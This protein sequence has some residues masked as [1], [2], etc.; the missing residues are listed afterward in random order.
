M[1]RDT[2][3]SAIVI[4]ASSGGL[5]ALS[6]LLSAIPKNYMLPIIVVQHRSKEERDLLETVLQHKCEIRIK[7]ADEKEKITGGFVYIAPPNY[8]LMVESDMTFSLSADA[9]VKFSRPSIDV[10]FETASHV[11]TKTLIGI[12]LTGSGSDGASGMLSIKENN[13]VTI[14]QD[15]QE[16][17][18]PAMPIAAIRTGA[19][20]RVL[21]LKEIV[22]FLKQVEKTPHEKL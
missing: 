11:Y 7:Q 21:P 15:P 16:A 20:N 17:H 12:I 22:A 5:H 13:G 10:L 2:Y 4:G 3:Y 6:T 9:L 8:H 1:Q 18:D 14:A 19:I